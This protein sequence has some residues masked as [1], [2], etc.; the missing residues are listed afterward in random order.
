MTGGSRGACP[1]LHRARSARLGLLGLTVLVGLVAGCQ[2]RPTTAAPPPPQRLTRAARYEGDPG[3][4]PDGR[5]VAYA[6]W[7]QA[8]RDLFV[9]DAEFKDTPRLLVGGAGT[10]THPRWSPD[11]QTIAFESDRG[12]SA[13]LWIVP[14]AGGEPK[15]LTVEAGRDAEPEWSPDGARLVFVSDRGSRD[16]LWILTLSTGTAE[17]LTMPTSPAPDATAAEPAWAGDRIYFAGRVGGERNIFSIIPGGGHWQRVTDGPARKSAPALSKEGRLAYL[18]DTTTYPNIYIR[19]ADG[20]VTAVTE[21]ATE[22]ARPAWTPDGRAL[23]Y[24]RRAP[25]GLLAWPAAGGRP[26]TAL[27]AQGGNFDPTWS[28]DGLELAYQSNRTGQDDIWRVG[29]ADHGAASVSS[30]READGEPDW[31]AAVRKIVYTAI[32]DGNSDIWTMDP[33]G[34]ELTNLTR[35]PAR[36]RTPRWSADGRWIVFVSDRGGSDDIW[37]MPGG[38]GVPR[39]LTEGPGAERSPALLHQGAGFL[40]VCEMEA[41]GIRALGRLP[42]GAD[43]SPIGPATRWTTPAAV[44]DWDG[45][46]DAAPDGAR[47]VF[48]RCVGGNRDLALIDVLGGAITSL[49]ADPEAQED[50]AAFAKDGARVAAE[51]GGNSDLWRVEAP[52]PPPPG[53]QR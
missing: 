30:S 25:W 51:S 50:H 17:S 47:V 39:R 5:Q 20:R 22:F 43:L 8:D 6:A 27:E 48:T 40:L 28:P 24:E 53:S 2:R 49:A 46:P 42:L 19:E 31:S 45:H 21:E 33:S 11:G 16:Q 34:I 44:G 36:D 9:T 18:S 52:V 15:R 13:D 35:D 4:S 38:G 23:V 1:A 12:G 14:A 10:D 29:L 26:D 7:G 32:H 3:L 41:D 37:V